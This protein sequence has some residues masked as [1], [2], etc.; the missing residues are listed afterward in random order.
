MQFRLKEDT[1]ALLRISEGRVLKNLGPEIENALAPVCVL[2]N[3]VSMLFSFR[4][5]RWWVS[6]RV[7][8]T[9]PF[10]QDNLF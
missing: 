9:T 7:E 1:E 6:L 10:E 8:R 5:V 3:S 2:L 4:V